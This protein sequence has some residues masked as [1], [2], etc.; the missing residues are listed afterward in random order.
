MPLLEQ[1]TI[2]DSQVYTDAHIL[3]VD[4][5]ELNVL[6]LEDILQGA[7]YTGITS[8]TDPRKVVSLFG[9]HKPDLI[10]LDLMM[11]FLNGF[12]VMEQLGSMIPEDS[13]LPIVVLTADIS[14]EAKR[15]ALSMGAQDFLTK[16]LDPIEVLLRVRNLLKTRLLQLQLVTQNQSLEEK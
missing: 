10:L 2:Q 4:D 8:T 12:Q 3:I 5:Q 1:K 16:P 13:F 11:P 9:K 6:L 7:G 14:T 15:Q